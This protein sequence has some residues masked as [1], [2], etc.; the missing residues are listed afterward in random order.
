MAVFC[1]RISETYEEFH[2]GVLPCPQA[3]GQRGKKFGALRLL[4]LIGQIVA[5]Y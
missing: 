3:W 1:A 2:G 5:C 4:E